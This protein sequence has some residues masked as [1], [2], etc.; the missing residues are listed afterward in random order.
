MRISWT[1]NVIVYSRDRRNAEK[2]TKARHWLR[3]LAER[4]W[5]VV[6]LHGPQLRQLMCSFAAL[7][8]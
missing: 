5:A 3:F 6:N 2:R 1:P 7:A 8:K 4:E